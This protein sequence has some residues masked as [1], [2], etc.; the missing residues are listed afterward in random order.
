DEADRHFFKALEIRPSADEVRSNLGSSYLKQRRL[1][2]AKRAFQD[3]VASNPANG[4]AQMGLAVCLEQEGLKREAHDAYGRALETDVSNAAA[5][6]GLMRLA[7]E[8]KTHA[9]AE[10]L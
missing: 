1:P 7:Y 3:A 5:L 9:Y 4:K 2:D 6:Y 10:K 8:L